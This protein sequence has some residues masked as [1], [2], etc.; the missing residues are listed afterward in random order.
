VKFHLLPIGHA[1]SWRGDTLTKSG[2]VTA[3]N[4]AGK[5]IMV[6]RSAAV[7]P[8]A[9]SED[10]AAAATPGQ[11]QLAAFEQFAEA[12]RASI[13]TLEGR[14]QAE[15]LA[16]LRA[17]IQGLLEDLLR[18]LNPPEDNAGNLTSAAPE[19]PASTRRGPR[20]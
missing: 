3:V 7:E 9:G 8:A 5:S 15:E 6:P 1:F 18:R 19:Q 10:S 14:L 11:R 12:L 17:D 16:S 4:A 20:S 2:P 13:D